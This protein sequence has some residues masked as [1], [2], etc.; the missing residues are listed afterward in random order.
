MRSYIL[1]T[2]H[3]FC[4]SMLIVWPNKRRLKSFYG[5]MAWRLIHLT[6]IVPSSYPFDVKIIKWYHKSSHSAHFLILQGLK[7]KGFAQCY[8][9]HFSTHPLFIIYIYRYLQN[10]LTDHNV[11][12]DIASSQFACPY[13][14]KGGD[15]NNSFGFDGTVFLHF[16]AVRPMR[17]SAPGSFSRAPVSSSL[18][19]WMVRDCSRTQS[20][21]LALFHAFDAAPFSQLA[22]KALSMSS[23][24]CAAITTVL[25]V[26]VWRVGCWWLNSAAQKIILGTTNNLNLSTSYLRVRCSLILFGRSLNSRW[27]RSLSIS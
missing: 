12:C 5:A 7:I 18:E 11:I 10:Y 8:I 6:L 1:S 9:L 22:E 19:P 3:K 25:R 17:K 13:M 4:S 24:S 26:A 14:Y 20:R 27:L 21:D 2:Y 15:L 16:T 23:P